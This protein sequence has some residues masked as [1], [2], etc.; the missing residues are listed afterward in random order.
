[1]RSC[2]RAFTLIEILVVIAIIAILA[3]ILFPV[4]ARAEEKGRQASCLSNV[5]Q[6][7]L[8]FQQYTSDYDGIFPKAV[9]YYPYPNYY[10][11]MF[12][13]HPYVHNFQMFT[14]P[15]LANVPYLGIPKTTQ[16]GGGYGYSI[17]VRGMHMSEVN[18]PTEV[19]LASDNGRLTNGNTYFLVDW[20]VP[21]GDNAVPPEA[22]HNGG[23]NFVFV[24]GH[25]KWMVKT[26]YADWSGNDV[27]ITALPQSVQRLWSLSFGTQP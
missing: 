17:T 7:G 26:S 3:A 12:A 6:L 27:S 15:S 14:C 13:L 19:V 11:W 8:A 18:S 23:A 20:D 4:F 1:M 9:I 5:R 2:L 21:V 24:D 16:N 22:R 10:T 25:T